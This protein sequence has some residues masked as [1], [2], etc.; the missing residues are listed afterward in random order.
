MAEDG[1]SDGR[2]RSKREHASVDYAA[3]EEGVAIPLTSD[4]YFMEPEDMPG[5]APRADRW[6]PLVEAVAFDPLRLKQLAGSDLTAAW[7]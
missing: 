4:F 1:E 7:W 3:I 6:A 5:H 2:R